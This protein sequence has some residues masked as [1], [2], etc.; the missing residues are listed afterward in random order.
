MKNIK[1]ARAVSQKVGCNNN[2]EIFSGVLELQ[3]SKWACKEGVEWLVNTL[4]DLF[5]KTEGDKLRVMIEVE[6][7][8]SALSEKDSY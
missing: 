7:I 5:D 6:A 2:L 4:E 8:F 1:K 3:S